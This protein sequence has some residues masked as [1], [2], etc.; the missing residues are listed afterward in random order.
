MGLFLLVSRATK[1]YHAPPSKGESKITLMTDVPDFRAIYNCINEA[2][3]QHIRNDNHLL[4]S[5]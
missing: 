2:S 1:V 4:S 5:A 3:A